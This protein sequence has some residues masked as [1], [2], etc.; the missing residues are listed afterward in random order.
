M[1][2]LNNELTLVIQLKKY[3]NE[4]L[5]EEIYNNVLSNINKLDNSL[6]P[7]KICYT[8]DNLMSEN[9][10]KVSRKY[11]LDRIKEKEVTLLDYKDIKVEKD[12]ELDVN[13]DILDKV[14]EIISKVLDKDI[15]EINIDSNFFFD[16]GG[17]SLDYYNLISMITTEFKVDINLDNSSSQYSAKTLAKLLE[18]LV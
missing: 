3:I 15:K 5:K 6:K 1:L 18:E 9:A 13:K 10:I 2:N 12:I 8:F 17:S 7:T 4:S 14:I 11:L 16:L